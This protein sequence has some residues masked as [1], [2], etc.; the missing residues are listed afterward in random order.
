[1]EHIRTPK[2][3]NVRLVDRISSKKAVL[4]TLYLTATHVIFVEN[5]PDTR[6]ETWILHSQISTI[7][8]QATRTLL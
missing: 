3:E 5:A 7:E 6:K 1:M 2:V 4:G 8:K